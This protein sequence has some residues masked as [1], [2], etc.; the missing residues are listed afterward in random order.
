[1]NMMGTVE[2]LI[3]PAN[4]EPLW[5]AVFFSS[6]SVSAHSQSL[7]FIIEYLADPLACIRQL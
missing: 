4:V 5:L 6:M 2:G 1:M 7:K 3:N